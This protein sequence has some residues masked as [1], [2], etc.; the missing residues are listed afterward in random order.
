[1]GMGVPMG[2][3]GVDVGYMFGIWGIYN[4]HCTGYVTYI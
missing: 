2:I 3:S 4:T 1:M